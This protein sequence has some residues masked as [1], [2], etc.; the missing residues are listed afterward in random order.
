[1]AK[2]LKLEVHNQQAA[3]DTLCS[4]SAIRDLQNAYPGKYE[5]KPV[6][7]YSHMWDFNP[8]VTNFDEADI[9]IKIGT[10]LGVNGSQTNGLHMCN[11][12]RL[13]IEEKLNLSIKQGPI[14]PD[15]HMSQEEKNDP[16]VI[17]GHYWLIAPGTRNQFTSKIW[18]Y[19]RWQEVVNLFPNILF[20]QIGEQQHRVPKLGGDNVVDYTGKTENPET[21]IRDLFKLCY[22]AQGGLSLVSFLMHLMGA[23]CKPCVVVAGAREPVSFEAYNYHRYLHNQGSMLCPKL[24]GKEFNNDITKACW[25]TS[26]E[27]CSNRTIDGY[28]KCLDMIEPKHVA[29]ALESYYIGGR[30]TR[31]GVP[32][33]L[34][35]PSTIVE[36]KELQETELQETELQEEYATT[37]ITIGPIKGE[38][39]KDDLVTRN[40]E[41]KEWE[42]VRAGNITEIPIPSIENIIPE[43]IELNRKTNPNP[44][45]KVVCNANGFGGG[46]KSPIW[47]M[48]RFI[49]E[50]WQVQLVPTKG[51]NNDFKSAT[52]KVEITDRLTDP[53]DLLLFYTN[54]S[55][56]N[57]NETKYQ[58][59]NNVKA[60]KKVMVLNYKLGKSVDDID[61]CN[62]WDSYIF[63]NNTIK[64]EFLKKRPTAKTVV[65]PP[66]VN[67]EP[68]LNI[69][70]G[71]LNKTLH[72]IRHS[73]QGDKKYPLELNDMILSIR[74]VDTKCKFSFMPAPSFLDTEIPGVSRLSIN[75]V[76]VPE[77]LKKGNLFWY[78]LPEGY[79]DQGPRVIIEAMATGLPVIADNRDGA[80]DRVTEDTG[81]LCNTHYEYTEVISNITGRE[82]SYKG[83]AAKERAREV[84]DPEQWFRAL[85]GI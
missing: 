32:V 59:F 76:P 82:L 79:T 74:K 26:V 40:E 69:D 71:S 42:V 80:K 77:F 72:L 23:F 64:D 2:V 30:L 28:P 81:W 65:L 61:W 47:L 38:P 5:V 43:A 12:Y 83:K 33:I 31:P 52:P 53:C 73:S 44:I 75:E 66:P 20:V 35:V 14:R 13:S 39:K 1:M 8:H 50:G 29:D 41:L 24:N 58:I 16:P 37:E 36:Y 7:N 21:G 48:N 49:K 15:I 4:T 84:F 11:A 45:F 19:E 34:Q 18:P 3:G 27:G 62:N 6:T 10:G 54:D 25:R 78:P 17:E 57:F 60:D 56:Y 67:L 85:L 55:V 46:E 51:V 22:H 63:L 70:L 9:I 68:F